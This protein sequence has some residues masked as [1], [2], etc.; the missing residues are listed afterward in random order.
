MVKRGK[1]KK[2]TDSITLK[3]PGS[4]YNK[5]ADIIEGTGFHSVTEFVVFVLRDL[6]AGGKIEKKDRLTKEEIEKVR[7]RLKKLGYL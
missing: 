3:I 6:A 7:K 5:I 2:P 4:V 1:K